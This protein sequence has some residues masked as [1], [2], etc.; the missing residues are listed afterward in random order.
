[1]S[2]DRSLL[3]QAFPNNPRLQK[4][5]EAAFDLLDTI[6]AQAATLEASLNEVAAQITTDTFQPESAILTSISALPAKT[7]AIVQTGDN[8]ADIRAIDGADN[9]SILS[10]GA[11]YTLLVTQ[12]GKGPTTSRPTLSSSQVGIYFDTTLAAGGK[13]IFWNRTNWVD[14][15]GASV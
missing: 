3:A 8:L 7:G 4:E 14:S 5:M 2:I 11:A 15:S 6:N 10:R 9:A 1:V 12:G 13:P